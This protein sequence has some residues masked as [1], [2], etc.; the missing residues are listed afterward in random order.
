LAAASLIFASALPEIAAYLQADEDTNHLEQAA[1]RLN[2][3]I[4]RR[5]GEAA[6]GYVEYLLGK[7]ATAQRDEALQL[8]RELH[9]ALRPRSRS[10][11]KISSSPLTI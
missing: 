7:A 3:V 1:V 11:Y 4:L 6:F 9:D 10:A 5:M 2:A 8:S